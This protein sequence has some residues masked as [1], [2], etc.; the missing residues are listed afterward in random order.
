MVL[1]VFGIAMALRGLWCISAW[2]ED[3]WNILNME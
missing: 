1:L 3:Q 2:L